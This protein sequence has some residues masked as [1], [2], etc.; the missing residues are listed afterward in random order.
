MFQDDQDSAQV[1]QNSRGIQS[2]QRSDTNN[3]DQN[4]P[5]DFYKNPYDQNNNSG[6]PDMMEMDFGDL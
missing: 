5:N 3:K 1:P 6:K 2:K 4:D